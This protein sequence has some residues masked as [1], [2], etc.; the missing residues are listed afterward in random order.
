MGFHRAGGGGR[1]LRQVCD[2]H[3]DGELVDGDREDVLALLPRLAGDAQGTGVAAG[4]EVDEYEP[5]DGFAVKGGEDVEVGDDRPLLVDRPGP[6]A[7]GAA[8]GVVGAGLGVA[9][10]LD[11]VAEPVGDEP[12]VVEAEAAGLDVEDAGPSGGQ[13]DVLAGDG[14]EAE[15]VA[16]PDDAVEG[17]GLAPLVVDAEGFGGEYFDVE[18]GEH[19]L[20][21]GDDGALYDFGDAELFA[22]CHPFDRVAVEVVV[23]G[24]FVVVCAAFGGEVGL[25]DG[26][27]AAG[28]GVGCLAELGAVL[29]QSGEGEGVGAQLGVAGDAERDHPFGPLLQV[30][31]ILDL[32]AERRRPPVGDHLRLRAEQALQDGD[33]GLLGDGDATLG[34][35]GD[36]VGLRPA[37]L[38]R[39][40]RVGDDGRLGRRVAGEVAGD[41][42]ERRVV[43]A[44]VSRAGHHVVT[45]RW[46]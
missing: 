18:A 32:F 41:A 3:A 15:V 10:E 46:A 23:L 28:D 22:A 39:L 6:F 8:V 40:G 43:G 11:A 16:E 20:P 31:L 42:L 29:L 33:R 45:A 14:G 19:R 17:A 27:G 25:C 24:E 9:G 34:A 21:G 5:A 30:G 1:G 37:V 36:E 12:G 44:G 26:L 35:Q 2:G 13:C 38:G 7:A 4:G